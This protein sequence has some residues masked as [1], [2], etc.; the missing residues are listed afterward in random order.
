MFA[1]VV[2]EEG[3]PPWRKAY[4]L[5]EVAIGSAPAPAN[6]LVLDARWR[7]SARH[8]RLVAKDGKYILVDL[9]S[10][11]GTWVNGRKMTAPQIVKETDVLMIGDVRVELVTLAYE[12]I[13]GKPVV[14][15]DAMERGLLEA[16]GHGDEASRGVYADWLEGHG[17]HPRAELLRIQQA[18]DGEADQAAI[19]A[20]TARMRELVA[21]IDV[22]W[23]A[24]ISKLPIENCP[25]FAF[26]CPKQW[27]ELALTPVEGE[28]F[29]GACERPVYYCATIDEARACRRR[30]VRGDRSREPALARRHGTAVR[31][32]HVPG[33]RLR[34]RRGAAALPA[35]RRTDRGAD[36][37]RPDRMTGPPSH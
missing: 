37:D 24:R 36:D 19:D 27:S 17:E 12:E 10:G 15:R 23:R 16:I 21:S 30:R 7:V 28:R 9:K 32:E 2:H 4:A 6:G 31:D 33:V 25:Q 13:A 26:Q 29:C 22:P 20:A 1:L 11:S 34:R 8:A 35:L 5:R 18:L 14:A 3:R